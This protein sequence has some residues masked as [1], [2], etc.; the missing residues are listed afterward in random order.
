MPKDA[1]NPTNV[2]DL[3]APGRD[4]VTHYLLSLPERVV[5]SA[6]ALAGGLARELGDVAL[7]AAVR[8]TKLY[9]NLVEATLRFLIEQVGEVEGVYPT[10][11]RLAEDFAFRRAAGNGI[12]LAGILAFRAS[13][14]WVMAALADI[15]GAGRHLIQEISESLQQEG[16]L[17]PGR[18]FET[19]DQILDGL[20]KS[21]GRT[22]E[23]IN[24][25]PLD[26]DGLR[27]EWAAIR[28]QVQQIPTPNVPSPQLV[29]RRW[30]ELRLTAEAQNCS[31]FQLSSL[32]AFSAVSNL[33]ANVRWLTRSAR[34]ASRRTGQLFAG[35]LLDHYDHT[36][37]E[38]RETG[39]L[40]YWTRQ[41][42]PYLR[43][44]AEQF[45]PRRSSLTQRFLRR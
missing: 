30:E 27:R 4:K 26:I 2:R 20:E 19:V 13:P 44:A 18:K 40:A 41:F 38:I 23:A 29:R 24:T 45:S 43:A 5:R 11:G 16:L 25:P 12:E 35:A 10:E 6:S 15:S 3:A 39:Y 31:V 28:Q 37:K 33:P 7:P 36:L 32:M 1:G 14:V 42:R 17:E 34:L 8:R 22:A 9:Q 21:A